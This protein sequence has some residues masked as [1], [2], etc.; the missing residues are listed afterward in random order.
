MGFHPLDILVVVGI[1]LLLFGPKTLQSISRSAG[2]GVSQVKGMKDK[3]LAELPMEDF[4]KVTDT[5]SQIP[6]SPQQAARKMITSATMPDEK[7]AG[8]AEGDAA[9]EPVQEPK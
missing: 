7:R 4:A 3:V 9:E 5:I 6:M 8:R 1:A 2:K